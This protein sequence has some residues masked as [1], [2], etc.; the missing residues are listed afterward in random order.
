MH[1]VDFIKQ[2]GLDC[3]WGA[4][5]VARKDFRQVLLS[6]ADF[7]EAEP[8]LL[9]GVFHFFGSVPDNMVDALLDFVEMSFPSGATTIPPPPS[10]TEF[11]R[12][13]RCDARLCG[14]FR[15][16]CPQSTAVNA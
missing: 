3:S 16:C 9:P 1:L 6:M 14:G 12:C 13:R 2:V 8:S 5:G 4:V 10:D 7:V 11:I 15:N